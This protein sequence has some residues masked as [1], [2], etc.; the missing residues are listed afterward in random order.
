MTTTSRDRELLKKLIYMSGNHIRPINFDYLEKTLSYAGYDREELLMCL[1]DLEA[2]KLLTARLPQDTHIPIDVQLTFEGVRF[3]TF[4]NEQF[5]T[6]LFKSVLIPALVSA[7][8]TL[9]TIFI[10]SLLNKG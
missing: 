7:L 10:H 1:S 6:F 5:K 4:R 3:F 2:A 9:I 8:T